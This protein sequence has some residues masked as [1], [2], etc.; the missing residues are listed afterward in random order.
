[1][2]IINAET[3]NGQIYVEHKILG[4]VRTIAFPIESTKEEIKEALL[5]LEKGRER[6]AELQKENKERWEKEA[7]AEKTVKDLLS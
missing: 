1:M 3:K 7:K 2:K 4:I 6:R 5:K